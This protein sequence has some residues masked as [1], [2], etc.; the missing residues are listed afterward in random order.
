MKKQA[1]KRYWHESLHAASRHLYLPIPI[2]YPVHPA[3][4]RVL[5]LLVQPAHFTAHFSSNTYYETSCFYSP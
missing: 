2:T 1:D 4:K 3:Y 5:Y